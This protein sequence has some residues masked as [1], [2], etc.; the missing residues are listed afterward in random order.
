MPNE[1]N[2]SERAYCDVTLQGKEMQLFFG[3]A[4]T[5]FV[6]RKLKKAVEVIFDEARIAREGLGVDLVACLVEAG[7]LHL[8]NKT[9]DEAWIDEAIDALPR[10]DDDE[11]KNGED[12][13]STLSTKVM[14]AFVRGLPTVSH[15]KLA[16]SEAAL[17]SASNAKPKA[18]AGNPTPAS[19]GSG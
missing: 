2:E 19:T 7:C 12:N 4:A 8:K 18:T 13:M 17:V 9:I 5:R 11:L 16:A 15:K 3:T 1:I 10:V 14:R 6:E